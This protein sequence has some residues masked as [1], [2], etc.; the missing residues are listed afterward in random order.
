MPRFQLSTGPTTYAA[1]TTKTALDLATPAGAVASIVK[2]WVASD[3]TSAGTATS[4]L[5]VQVGL[6]TAAVATHTGITPDPFDY[7][8]SGV[9]SAM[10]TGVAITSEGSGVAAHIEEHVLPLTQSELIVWEPVGR[11]VPVSSFFRIR[12]IT[13]AGIGTTNIYAGIAWD[14]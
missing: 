2:W 14:E 9:A 12:L 11:V 10:T 4:G 6:F 8:G 3:A 7:G 5:R 13:P 1:S